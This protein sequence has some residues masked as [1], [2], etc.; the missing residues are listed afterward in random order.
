MCA[1]LFSFRPH[2]RLFFDERPILHGK[3]VRNRD[4]GRHGSVFA[5][6][7]QVMDVKNELVWIR[8]SVIMGLLGAF[9]FG[10]FII[11]EESNKFFN[12]VIVSVMT[13]CAV[14]AACL[15]YRGMRVLIG[16]LEKMKGDDK[17]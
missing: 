15:S 16:K 11:E 5:G 1:A 4:D 7:G 14:Y 8:G 3:Y 2:N 10:Y 12:L 13:A 9:F 6:E 17:K